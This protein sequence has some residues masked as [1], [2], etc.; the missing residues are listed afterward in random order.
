MAHP[1]NEEHS[2]FA[3]RIS[4]LEKINCELSELKEQRDE[5]LTAIQEIVTM[6]KANIHSIEFPIWKL[7]QLEQLIKKIK[8]NE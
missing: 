3:D 6:R 2:E 5:M 4:D 8:Q 1:D 7:E